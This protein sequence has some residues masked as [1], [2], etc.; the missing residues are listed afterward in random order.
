MVEFSIIISNF[1]SLGV[2][3]PR[4]D[5]LPRVQVAFQ[6]SLQTHPLVVADRQ[7]LIVLPDIRV[8]LTLERVVARVVFL[9]VSDVPVLDVVQRPL[10]RLQRTSRLDLDHHRVQQ[11]LPK[12][13][14]VY[15]ES[16]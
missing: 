9:L 2:D 7:L 10:Q 16:S 12:W 14:S 11:R 6:L 4:N 15:L 13:R 1:L 3:D 5:R 8:A